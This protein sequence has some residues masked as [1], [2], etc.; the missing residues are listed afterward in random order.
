MSN[1]ILCPHRIDKIFY[2]F[3]P[4]R[5][6]IAKVLKEQSRWMTCA[7]IA[8]M[9]YGITARQVYYHLSEILKSPGGRQVI[10]VEKG[11][12]FKPNRFRCIPEV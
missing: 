3:E 4:T 7:E 6:D 2:S 1:P 12:K 9:L 5:Y 8:E 10:E 11:E